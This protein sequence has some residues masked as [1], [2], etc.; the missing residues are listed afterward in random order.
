MSI[1]WRYARYC[2][3]NSLVSDIESRTLPGCSLVEARKEPVPA[4]TQLGRI[5]TIKLFLTGI[6]VEMVTKL[7]GWLSGPQFKGA[8]EVA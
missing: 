8:C 1:V 3:E 2:G 7:A 6:I 4:M 5:R